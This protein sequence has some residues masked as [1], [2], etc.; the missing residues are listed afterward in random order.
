L[1]FVVIPLGCIWYGKEIGSFSMSEE[2]AGQNPL[3]LMI[4]LLGWILLV[5]MLALLLWLPD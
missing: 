3:G 4:T 2:N 1:A 5:G